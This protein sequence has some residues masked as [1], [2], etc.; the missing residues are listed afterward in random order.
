MKL[1]HFT[2]CYKLE[3]SKSLLFHT[4]TR[5][6]VVIQEEVVQKMAKTDDSADMD[7]KESATLKELG[8]LVPKTLNEYYFYQY[9]LNKLRFDNSHLYGTIL[10]TYG[11]NLK[12]V[13]CYEEGVNKREVTMNKSV[14]RVTANWFA[15]LVCL[16][17]PR[18][19]DINFFGGEPLMNFPVIKQIT[20]E[21]GKELKDTEI[22]YSLTTNGTLLNSSTFAKLKNI[23]F[24]A[25]QI[26][27]DGPEA[28]HNERRP[29]CGGRGTFSLIMD[30]IKNI[31][32]DENS[33]RV[34]L[35]VNYDR[36]NIAKME[37]LF[38]K[39][40]FLSKDPRII[41]TINAV[42]PF[43]KDQTHCSLFAFLPEEYEHHIKIARIAME[44][45]F[46]VDLG[47]FDSGL[48]PSESDRSFIVDPEGDVYA[49]ITGVGHPAFKVGNILDRL[50]TVEVGISQFRGRNIWQIEDGVNCKDCFLLPICRG[51]CRA[52]AFIRYQDTEKKV[53]LKPQLENYLEKGLRLLYETRGTVNNDRGLSENPN[54]NFLTTA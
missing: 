17:R 19:L 41:I 28:I 35:N 29:T 26:T 21:L 45:G 37:E 48:C 25:F 5:A 12:C 39:L 40:S 24:K 32:Q 52:E 47:F 31:L 23:G 1:S 4:L 2:A 20:C 11:C 33:I 9:W 18:I 38:E 3:D 13:Y 44:R 34:R 49:C 14:A 43:S 16:R 10:T 8:F 22:R 42:T 27:I 6:F 50:S 54:L 51:W 46:R 15:N 7:I 30:N 53:C 36:H